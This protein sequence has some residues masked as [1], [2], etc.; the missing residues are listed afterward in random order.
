[1]PEDFKKLLGQAIDLK[2]QERYSEAAHLLENLSK[3]YPESASVR[4]LLGDAL[5]EQNDLG[6]AVASFRQAV[7]LAPNSETAS[8]GLFHT[9][10]ESGD[11]QSAIAEMSRFL[12]VSD[13]EEYKVLARSLGDKMTPTD[14]E[15]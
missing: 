14:G 6:G 7:K 13:S 15:D 3:S 11:R 12:T 8:L 10:L 4:A 2:N 1:M 5:W 9:L